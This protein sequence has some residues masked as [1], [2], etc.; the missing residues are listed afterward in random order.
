[1]L[2]FFFF[3]AKIWGSALS[4]E[5]S[6]SVRY[7]LISS[8]NIAKWPF[9]WIKHLTDLFTHTIW[10]YF[11][12]LNLQHTKISKR[13]C[14]HISRHVLQ[15]VCFPVWNFWV[16][17]GMCKSHDL[18]LSFA[19]HSMKSWHWIYKQFKVKLVFL[20]QSMSFHHF[21]GN[22][23]EIIF[24]FFSIW[25]K[26]NGKEIKILKFS[27]KKTFIYLFIFK[28]YCSAFECKQ[29]RS[30]NWKCCRVI[31]MMGVCLREYGCEQP[32]AHQWAGPRSLFVATHGLVWCVVSLVS[33][34]LSPW[35]CFAV[36]LFWFELF[37]SACVSLWQA[38]PR[39]ILNLIVS[40]SLHSCVLHFHFLCSS[41]VVSQAC[42]QWSAAN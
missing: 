13:K 19:L 23:V 38:T 4:L 30:E 32:C 17:I 12:Q 1:M 8:C 31:M 28:V 27:K 25:T 24:K 40:N 35:A 5:N 3:N 14:D 39:V 21:S 33:F 10:A 6:R 18:S 2:I 15:F 36:V 42:L 9:D 34:P 20:L 41:F 26:W 37:C 11:E 16:S 7:L 29:V 22:C